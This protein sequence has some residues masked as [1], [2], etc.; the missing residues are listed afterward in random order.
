MSKRPVTGLLTVFIVSLGILLPVRAVSGPATEAVLLVA[1]V[2]AFTGDTGWKGG[3]TTV[4]TT[5]SSSS[6]TY[7]ARRSLFEVDVKGALMSTMVGE[8]FNNGLVSSSKAAQL[9]STFPELLKLRGYAPL[10]KL[11]GI[12]ADGLPSPFATSRRP[13]GGDG[14]V[15]FNIGIPAGIFTGK[16]DWGTD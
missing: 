5:A 6:C 11:P 3:I 8:G 7:D 1:L 12:C 9:A 4:S 13:F 15:Q 2:A 16:F 14:T 10:R